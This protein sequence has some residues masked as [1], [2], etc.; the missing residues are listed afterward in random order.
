[1]ICS[2]ASNDSFCDQ[3]DRFFW[4]PVDPGRQTGAF[5]ALHANSVPRSKEPGGVES[6][7]PCQVSFNEILMAWPQGCHEVPGDYFVFLLAK[8]LSK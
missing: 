2:W 1:M 3:F 6:K 8:S 4:D 7:W 5:G